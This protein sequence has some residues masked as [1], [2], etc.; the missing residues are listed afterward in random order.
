[1]PAPPKLIHLDE[2][3]AVPGPGTLTWLPVRHALGIHAFGCNAYRADEAG[4]DVVEPHIEESH[5][6]LYFV[7]SGRATFTIDG[8][9]YNAP[10]GTYV[11]LPDPD[12]HR[13]ATADEPGTVVL[14]FGGPPTFEP[15][16]WEWAFRAAALQKT[17]PEGAVAI[18]EDG[19]RVKP[20]DGL[21]HYGMAC[22][23][24][25]GGHS[26]EALASLARAIELRPDARE[27][28]RKDSDFDGLRDDERFNSLTAS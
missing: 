23:Q 13:H 9:T 20:D 14:S 24:A 5:E 22:A 28:A 25:L 7:A 19:L 18:L 1:M 10:A 3:D 26:A 11:F 12:S 4:T 17:D 6:E 2:L 8:Q 15:S 27:W 16:A 21:L